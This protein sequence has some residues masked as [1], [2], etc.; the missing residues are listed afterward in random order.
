M[1]QL[2]EAILTGASLIVSKALMATNPLETPTNYFWDGFYAAGEG[3]ALEDMPT[4]HHESGWWAANVFGPDEQEPVVIV[5]RAGMFSSSE[6]VR[7][8]EQFWSRG[9]W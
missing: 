5:S 2:N 7:E 9:Q 8:D 1:T 4:P 6:D 3:Q